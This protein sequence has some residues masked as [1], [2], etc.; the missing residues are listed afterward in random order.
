M[1]G[2]NAETSMRFHANGIIQTEPSSYM[3]LPVIQVH[4]ASMSSAKRRYGISCWVILSLPTYIEAKLTKCLFPEGVREDI[5]SR[6]MAN[7]NLWIR[8]ISN[9]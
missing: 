7:L 8:S 3:H 2:A 5:L 1:M 6:N 4:L 9:Y